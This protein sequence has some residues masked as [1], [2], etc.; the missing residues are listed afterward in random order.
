MD[1]LCGAHFHLPHLDERV[2]EV[3]IQRVLLAWSARELREGSLAISHARRPSRASSS[4]A[5][6]CL[7][8]PRC[9]VLCLCAYCAQLTP[10]SHLHIP[11][12]PIRRWALLV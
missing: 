5:P 1:A 8:A 7:V 4:P 9:G 11:H 12:I 2:L 6:R 10:L 3:R